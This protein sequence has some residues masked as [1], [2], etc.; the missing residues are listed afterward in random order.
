MKDLTHFSIILKKTPNESTS[1]F[2]FNRL[3][4]SWQSLKIQVKTTKGDGQEE[5]ENNQLLLFHI[6]LIEKYLYNS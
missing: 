4:S 1:T 6:Q 5:E 3:K 2:D